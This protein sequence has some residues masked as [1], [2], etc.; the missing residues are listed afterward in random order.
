MKI[1]I[2]LTLISLFVSCNSGNKKVDEKIINN[3]ISINEEKNNEFMKL[4]TRQKEEIRIALKALLKRDDF[5]AF[6][7]IRE[8][9]TNKFIQFAINEGS[10]LFDFPSN[11]LNDNQLN[12]AK[13][14]LSP[15]QILFE[16]QKAYDPDDNTKVVGEFGG[17]SK[18]IN[19]DFDQAI[20]IIEKIITQVFDVNGEINLIIDEN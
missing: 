17:F 10:L 5:D 16:V 7:I 9:N 12:I 3:T 18:K 6:I 15:Y 2:S 19:N 4:P 13:K 20:E 11:Q 1:I 14:I 8:Q